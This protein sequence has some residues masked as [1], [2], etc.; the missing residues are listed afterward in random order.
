MPLSSINFASNYFR[1]AN[2]TKSMIRLDKKFS[3]LKAFSVFWQLIFLAV[4]L[5]VSKK[6]QDGL[7]GVLRERKFTVKP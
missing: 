7:R 5:R 2:F 1:A 3:G 6:P 4:R